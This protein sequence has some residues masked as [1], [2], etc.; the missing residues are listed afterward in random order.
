MTN[1]ESSRQLENWSRFVPK[2]PTIFFA[3]AVVRGIFAY[4]IIMIL[5]N[6]LTCMH[7][8]FI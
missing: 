5:I 2:R 6:R 8:F 7:P 4:I 1:F 3:I